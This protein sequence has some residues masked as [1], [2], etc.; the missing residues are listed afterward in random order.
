MMNGWGKPSR[1]WPENN[2]SNACFFKS[3]L[4]SNKSH[5][6]IVKQLEKQLHFR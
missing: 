1:P 6:A 5:V 4:D 2:F 3:A